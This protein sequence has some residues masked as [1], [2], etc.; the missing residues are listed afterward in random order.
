MNSVLFAERDTKATF[1]HVF[2]HY[3]AVPGLENY[4]AGSH[5]Y[6]VEDLPIVHRGKTIAR[7]VGERERSAFFVRLSVKF[8][9]LYVIV[10]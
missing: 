4:L 10:S 6:V 5:G 9:V 2:P 3:C 7:F 8:I 1:H